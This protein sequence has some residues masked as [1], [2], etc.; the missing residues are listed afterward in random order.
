MANINF[1]EV[2]NAT[3]AGNGTGHFDTIMK[4]ALLHIKKEY[5]ENRIKGSDYANVYLGTIQ[6]AMQQAIQFALQEQMTEAQIAATEA[7]TAIKQAQSTK[8]LQVKD[9]QIGKISVDTS[10]VN[11]ETSTLL[12]AQKAL[13]NRQ[14]KGFDDDAKQ[15]LLKQTLDSWSVAY[16]VAQDANAIPDTI[17][18]SVIDSITKNAMSSLGVVATGQTLSA[19]SLGINAV[20]TPNS[21]TSEPT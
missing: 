11:Y 14:E 20:G 7:D 9:A 16:S 10:K 5:D 19:N 2:T 18:T 6:S 13:I 3:A 21:A 1:S 15:K 12:P 8:D 4:S 17:T